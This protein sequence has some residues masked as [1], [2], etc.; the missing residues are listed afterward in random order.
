MQV[1]EGG[2]QVHLSIVLGPRAPLR[3]ILAALDGGLARPIAEDKAGRVSSP[4]CTCTH[5]A[6]PVARMGSKV[7]LHHTVTFVCGT[8]YNFHVC[9]LEAW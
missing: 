4:T 1:W 9:V 3:W 7:M 5:R 2:R 6:Y 8:R